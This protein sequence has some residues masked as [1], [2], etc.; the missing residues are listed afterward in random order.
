MNISHQLKHAQPNFNKPGATCDFG[1]KKTA[2]NPAATC[3]FGL[4]QD[5]LSESVNTDPGLMPSKLP[6]AETP[7]SDANSAAERV[8]FGA[9][10]GAL[11]GGIAPGIA[12]PFVGFAL[13][14]FT[15]V[16]GAGIGAAIAFAVGE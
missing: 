5:G 3:T 7:K 4:P 16:A 13:S 9:G 11:I 8:A 15:M 12:I 6:A 2:H 10:M 14:P 1:T